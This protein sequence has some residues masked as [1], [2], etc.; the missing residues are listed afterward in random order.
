MTPKSNLIVVQIPVKSII[1]SMN[2]FRLS[3]VNVSITE[4]YLFLFVYKIHEDITIQIMIPSKINNN[5]NNKTK[6][7][8][9]TDYS[10]GLA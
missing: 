10:Q 2:L 8:K 4:L 9:S 6:W 7:N 3:C 1:S 5:N